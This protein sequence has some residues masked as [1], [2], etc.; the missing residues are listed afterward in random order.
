[1]KKLVLFLQPDIHLKHVAVQ[2]DK[3]QMALNLK[4]QVTAVL[5]LPYA[6]FEKP[7][8]SEVINTQG[9]NINNLEN[10]ISEDTN[11]AHLS[12]LPNGPDEINNHGD[13]HV[14]FIDTIS[15]EDLL[16]RFSTD[17][18]TQTIRSFLIIPGESVLN[19]ELKIPA[20]QLKLAQKALPYLV[21]DQIASDPDDCFIALGERKGDFISCAIIQRKLMSEYF[22]FLFDQRLNAEK[23][24]TDKNLLTYYGTSLH[25]FENR[26][27]LCNPENEAFAFDLDLLEIYLEKLKP[28]EEQQISSAA[29]IVVEEILEEADNEEQLSSADLTSKDIVKDTFNLYFYQK[30][31][32][33][34]QQQ[35]K[36]V[37][38][39][40]ENYKKQQGLDLDIESH[41]KSER[42]FYIELAELA[43]ERSSKLP[44]LNLLQAEFKAKRIASGFAFKLNVNWK[45]VGILLAAFVLLYFIS[46]FVEAKRY[47]NAALV[48]DEQTK[49]VFNEIYPNTNNYTRMKN[50]VSSLLK[51]S[52]APSDNQFLRIFFLFSEAMHAINANKSGSIIPKQIQY[53]QSNNELRVDVIASDFETLNALKEKIESKSMQMDI[54]STSTE[55]DGVKGRLKVKLV[56]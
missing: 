22:S 41:I 42:Y 29:E 54:S 37:H 47:Q 45:P 10:S 50:R 35:K 27:I 1:L 5:I 51:G 21:E 2:K 28:S 32:G 9:E 6:H 44:L 38:D 36:F 52:A 20:K 34:I 8:V 14:E 7:V 26:A 4:S 43:C 33:D 24:L 55:E 40:L 30:D 11:S 31:H 49:S 3:K 48:A 23:I 16:E 56:Q 46:I 18:N 39:S 25:V 53:E 17:I 12:I 19:C 13:S 15:V